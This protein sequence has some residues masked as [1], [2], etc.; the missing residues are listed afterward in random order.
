MK[1]RY[2]GLIFFWNHLYKSLDGMVTK[3]NFTGAIF[4]SLINSHSFK[5]FLNIKLKSK[6]KTDF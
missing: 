5:L 4:S 3:T 2:P 1:I 6:N